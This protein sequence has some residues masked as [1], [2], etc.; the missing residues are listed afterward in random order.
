MWAGLQRGG[1]IGN[2]VPH[3]C[4]SRWPYPILK[5]AGQ[6]PGQ[7]ELLRGRGDYGGNEWAGP[8]LRAGLRG[9]GD[10]R[11]RGTCPIRLGAGLEGNLG[12]KGRGYST[13]GRGLPGEGK[14]RILG[15]G[16]RRSESPGRDE[17]RIL[18]SSGCRILGRGGRGMLGG[19]GQA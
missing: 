6:R 1:S 18:G 19:A 15:H 16:G 12:V 10:S 17:I 4:V 3:A 13:K 2:H 11:K 9:G 7:T 5:G 14:E 8:C